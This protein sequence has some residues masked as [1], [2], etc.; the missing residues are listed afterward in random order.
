MRNSKVLKCHHNRLRFCFYAIMLILIQRVR[1]KF[2]LIEEILD[3]TNNLYKLFN[4]K[5]KSI[6][7]KKKMFLEKI[8]ILV[9]YI[10]LF[11]SFSELCS[12]SQS[13]NNCFYNFID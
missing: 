8:N 3:N 9:K 10:L 1:K 6:L 5:K 13:I 2:K 12:E 11:L 4:I 7:S